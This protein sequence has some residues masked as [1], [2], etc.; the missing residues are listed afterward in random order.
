MLLNMAG[1][2]LKQVLPLGIDRGVCVG[3]LGSKRC[4]HVGDGRGC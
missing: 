2:S 3:G 1:G 4:H